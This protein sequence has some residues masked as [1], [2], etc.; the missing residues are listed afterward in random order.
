M[1]QKSQ[2]PECRTKSLNLL[3]NLGRWWCTAC[4]EEIDVDAIIKKWSKEGV[5]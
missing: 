5:Q 1:S 4:K 2:C 3:K